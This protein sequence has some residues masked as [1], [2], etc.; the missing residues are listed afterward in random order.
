L[1]ALQCGIIRGP[2]AHDDMA[3]ACSYNCTA[4]FLCMRS[5]F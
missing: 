4:L 3:S 1:R 5:S 2:H